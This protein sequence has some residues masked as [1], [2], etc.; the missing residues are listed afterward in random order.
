[1]KISRGVSYKKNG[2]KIFVRNDNTA[3]DYLFDSRAGEILDYVA[4]NPN[5]S[6]PTLLKFFVARYAERDAEKI[7]RVFGDY[8]DEMLGEEILTELD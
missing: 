2:N 1:M 7:Q 5:R 6:V 4:A 3:R 8:V